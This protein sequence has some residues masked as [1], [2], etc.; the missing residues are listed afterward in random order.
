MEDS[1]TMSNMT[2]FETYSA[3]SWLVDCLTRHPPAVRESTQKRS[4]SS[5]PSALTR[6][7]SSITACAA[8]SCV[9]VAT[10]A[11]SNP[12]AV[13]GTAVAA[14]LTN[15]QANGQNIVELP[16]VFWSR[17]IAEVRGWRP[18]EEQDVT[19]PPLLF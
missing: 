9:N 6:M 16:S 19:D 2:G 1:R 18:I 11:V 17:A 14:T 8:L 15:R 7:L 5:S 10:S 4:P 3:Q 12:P 13:G